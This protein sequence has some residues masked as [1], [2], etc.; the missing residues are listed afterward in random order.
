MLKFLNGCA[1][2]EETVEAIYRLF[3]EAL[4]EGHALRSVWLKL[5]DD[6]GEHARQ[7]RL[8]G[9]LPA[10]DIFKGA[11]LPQSRV[12]DLLQKARGLLRQLQG[13][14]PSVTD[15]LKLSLQ[16]ETEFSEVHVALAVEFQDEGIRRMF[17]ALASG[18][19]RHA[20][21]L[22]HF[23]EQEKQGGGS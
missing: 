13:A 15:A 21:L 14:P 2:I 19:E 11:S 20:N 8:A 7:I 10:R 9:R 3:A 18:D 16:M 1:E 23:L 4:P 5:A 17:Q 22:R 12:D 6:E